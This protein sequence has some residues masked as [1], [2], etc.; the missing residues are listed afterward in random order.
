MFHVFESTFFSMFNVFEQSPNSQ[1]DKTIINIHRVFAVA[2]KINC[3]LCLPPKV[4][5][6]NFPD[7]ETKQ[8]KKGGIIKITLIFT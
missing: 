3:N 5:S 6:L 8:E 2:I 1:H 7:P 4:N